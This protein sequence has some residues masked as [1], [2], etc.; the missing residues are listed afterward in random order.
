MSI[1]RG[2]PLGYIE[3]TVKWR[4][5]HCRG[6]VITDREGGTGLVFTTFKR[7]RQID[8]TTLFRHKE[9]FM[10]NFC[11]WGQPSPSILHR[12]H[13][14]LSWTTPQMWHVSKWC[15]MKKK[16]VVVL[17]SL[18]IR[19]IWFESIDRKSYTPWLELSARNFHALKAACVGE[20]RTKQCTTEEY[21]FPRHVH[22]NSRMSGAGGGRDGKT[23]SPRTTLDYSAPV[24]Y[25][26]T[27]SRPARNR[28]LC[29]KSAVPTVPIKKKQLKNNCRFFSSKP[30]KPR[31]QNNYV[32]R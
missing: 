30:C 6:V 1:W 27:P 5:F 9:N 13:E 3:E 8:N 14:E 19:S 22:L 20:E 17:C 28:V 11:C 16:T 29:A 15:S 12:K 24:S 31:Q 26:P 7:L 2:C 10:S 18:V 21:E 25:D 32:V 4:T 23:Q